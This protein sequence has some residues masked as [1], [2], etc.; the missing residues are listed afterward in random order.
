MS[1]IR[2]VKR[3]N[4]K[5]Y[6]RHLKWAERALLGFTYQN[7]I[8]ILHP[9]QEISISVPDKMTLLLMWWNC[10]ISWPH[11][12][13]ASVNDTIVNFLLWMKYTYLVLVCKTKQS[14]FCQ[15]KMPQI[16]LYFYRFTVRMHDMCQ[17]SNFS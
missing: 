13:S 17:I 16:W 5:P 14:P 4:I 1:C 11:N 9:K 15:F 10:L 6:L 7:H 8:Y 12:K 2:T 3:L